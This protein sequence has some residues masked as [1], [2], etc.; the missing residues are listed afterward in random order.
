MN[1]KDVETAVKVGDFILRK[2]NR[3]K[4]DIKYS[5]DLDKKTLADE[6]ARIYLIT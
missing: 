3:N 1:I 4:I 5:P 2:K 6:S